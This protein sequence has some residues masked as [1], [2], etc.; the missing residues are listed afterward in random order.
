MPQ[1][2]VTV[3]DKRVD[4]PPLSAQIIA[5]RPH[6]QRSRNGSRPRLEVGNRPGKRLI[7]RCLEGA[8]RDLSFR[9][10]TIL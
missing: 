1:L 8:A 7:E 9:T 2:R 5:D 10:S 6:L 3:V 4:L